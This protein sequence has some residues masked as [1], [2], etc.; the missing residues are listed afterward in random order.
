MRL[1]TQ[2]T[3]LAR[4][5]VAA[6]ITAL[7][8]YPRLAMWSERTHSVLFLWLMLL[9]AVFVLWAFVFAWQWEY[10]HRPV[11][12]LTFSPKLWAIATLCGVA[13]AALLYFLIDPQLRVITPKEFPT[14][15]NSWLAMSLFAIGFDPL[16]LCFAPFAFFARL[17]RRPEVPVALTV[18]FGISVFWLR[19][20]YSPVLPAPGFIALMMTM[21]LAAGFL[22]V[23]F[24]L[25]GGALLVWWVALILQL[26]HLL[27]LAA[28][29]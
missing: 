12:G 19:M 9:W 15:G 29:Q 1:L 17:S 28:K 27:D 14:D 20:H 24:Y 23:W 7:A 16:F 26:R 18:L 6:T 8:C 13:W 22:S 2:P 3:V 21:R 25:R 11:L 5:G 4:A 10:G